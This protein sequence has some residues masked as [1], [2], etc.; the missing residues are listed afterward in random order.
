MKKLF[1]FKK[2]SIKIAAVIGLMVVVVAGGVAGYMQTRIVTEIGRLSRL[3]LQYQLFELE[4][5]VSSVFAETIHMVESLRILMSFSFDQQ[6]FT[7]DPEGHIHYLNDIF[8]RFFYEMIR[9]SNYISATYFSVHPRLSNY[10]IMGEIYY[11]ETPAGIVFADLVPYEE[12]I[13][14]DP[15]ML[16]FFGAYNS[17][18][19]FWSPIYEDAGITMVSYSVPVAINGEIIG[20]VGADISV[21]HIQNLISAVH[22]YETGFSLLKCP[23]GEFF[24]TNNKF[25]NLPATEQE[26]LIAVALANPGQ[27]FE[28]ELDNVIYMAA[29]HTLFSGYTMYLMAPRNEVNA[30]VIASV[31]RFAVIFVVALSI[32]LVIAYFVGK[33]L[34]NRITVLSSFMKRAAKTGNLTLRDEDKA[35][36]EL[37]TNQGEQK[38]EIGWLACD[39]FNLIEVISSMMDDLTTLTHELNVKGDIDYRIDS[40]PYKGSLKEMVDGINDMVTGIMDD[41]AEILRGITA[42]CNGEDA[43]VRNMSGKKAEFTKQF[44][45]LEGILDSFVVDLTDLA[46]S[47]A[48]G[49]LETLDASSYNGGWASIFGALNDLITAV[50]E[51]LAEIEHTLTQMSKG[52][53]EEMTGNY[54]GAFDSVKRAVNS[55]EETTLSYIEE[56][57]QVLAAVSKG[58]LTV[59]VHHDYKGSYAPIKE[60]L[61]VIVNSLN[62]TMGSISDAARHVQSGAEQI[63]ESASTLADG[64]S[65]QAS[66]VEELNASI[67]TINE[68][69][70]L[71]ASRARD[72]DTLSQKSNENAVSSNDEMKRMVLTMESI[73][74]SSANISKIIKVIEDISFQTNLLALNAAVEAAR[75]GDHGK[76]FAVVAEEVRNLAARSQE[77]AQETTTRISESIERANDGMTAAQGTALSLDTIVGD[78]RQVSGLISQIAKLSEEQAEAISE[79]AK[80]IGEISSVVQSNSATSQECAAASQELNSQAQSLLEMVSFF[81]L[82][83]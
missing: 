19:P 79:I 8:G 58:D 27:V 75:A 32:V 61:N 53:F 64:T 28:V 44:N 51:P 55:T 20:V 59:T 29:A 42:I 21:E 63:S 31:M 76:G 71:N 12:F 40:S 15:E 52:E 35:A 2:L 74:E 38:D 56:I 33:P 9:N 73:N 65:K 23:H 50:A 26:K 3:E 57:A 10:T 7:Q 18:M 5:D 81:K 60:A 66:S 78:V 22:I 70:S 45:Q 77:S 69:T 62:S 6:A 46:K 17:R 37:Y 43:Q 30:E 14:E 82:A 67:E 48:D 34:G 16:W 24:D 11:Y 83:K 68:K 13:A 54:K 4:N 47:A 39:F 80:G 25:N 49:K 36:L 1:S 72:A 41:I